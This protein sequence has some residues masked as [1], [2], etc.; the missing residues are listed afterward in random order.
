MTLE[1]GGKTPNI[2]LADADLDAAIKGAFIGIFFNPGQACNAGSRLFVERRTS[3]TRWFEPRRVRSQ[4]AKVGPGLD[5]ET[6]S[7]ARWSPRS[8]SAASSATSTPGSRRAPRRSPAAAPANGGGYFVDPTLFTGVSDEMK[9]AREEIFGPV[10][11]AQP[12]DDLEEVARRANDTD[13][14]L[15]AGLWTRD[16]SNA[17]KLAALL[18]AGSST[19]TPGAPAT[20]RRR[21]AA[22]RRR[23]SGARRATTTSTPTSRRSRSSPSSERVPGPGRAAAARAA[24][25]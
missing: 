22:T 21:S 16:V 10:L 17:H 20:R 6:S 4:K 5:P 14:G 25:A 11:V 7:S 23:A 15:A 19:S 1:L 12:F 24:G 9:I 18:K 13:Y 3:S 8:S 2:I